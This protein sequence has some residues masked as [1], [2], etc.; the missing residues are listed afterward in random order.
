MAGLPQSGA[1][2]PAQA[3]GLPHMPDR[4]LMGSGIMPDRKMM[5]SGIS[6]SS[7]AS[8]HSHHK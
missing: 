8:H 6:D 1:G 4:K 5:G 3:E 7:Q 2:G